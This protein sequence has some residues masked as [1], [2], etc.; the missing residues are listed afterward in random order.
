[1]SI[2]PAEGKAVILKSWQTQYGDR[3]TPTPPQGTPWSGI[4]IRV[5]KGSRYSM[6]R[7]KRD[8]DGVTVDVAARSMR[9]PKAG[10]LDAV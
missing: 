8:Y 9:Y 10:E 6:Y 1:M 7:V 3:V 5:Y 2:R 4:V